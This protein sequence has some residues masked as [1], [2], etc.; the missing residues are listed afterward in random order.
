MQSI[1]EALESMLPAFS[2][3][4][5]EEVPLTQS[6]GR[7]LCQDIV[8]V[9]DSPPFDNS[10]M[11]GYAV[12]AEDVAGAAQGS[13]VRLPVRGESRA[14]GALPAPLEPRSACRIFTGAP[15]PAGADAVVI[16]ADTERSGAEV[17]VVE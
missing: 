6:L 5:E 13:A 7:Y 4:G 12:R 10:A 15:M 8:A 3:L 17:A 9:L 1:A 14:G 11:D 2:T 16:Q